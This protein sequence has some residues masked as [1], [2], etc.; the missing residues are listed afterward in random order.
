MKEGKELKIMRKAKSTKETIAENE[1][2]MLNVRIRKRILKALKLWTVQ[3]DTTIK[4]FVTETLEREVK[5]KG[6]L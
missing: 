1:N 2:T 4:E 6:A 5:Q 3:N